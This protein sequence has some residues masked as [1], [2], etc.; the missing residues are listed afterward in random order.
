MRRKGLVKT[1][2]VLDWPL[3]PVADS[4][5]ASYSLLLPAALA[6]R[7]LAFAAAEILA[8]PAADMVRLRLVGA[9]PLSLAQRA[10]AAA[11]MRARPAALIRRLFLVPVTACAAAPS[12]PPRSRPNLASK[13]S[14][15]SRM[16]MA[17]LNCLTD[18]LDKG[19]IYGPRIV[20]TPAGRQLPI[21]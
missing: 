11:A 3:P 10:R 14:M 4:L 20:P 2:K 13:A 16:V 21:K 6:L 7:H 5:A 17:C 8:R 15:R 12:E 1:P 18:T 9:S 19:F